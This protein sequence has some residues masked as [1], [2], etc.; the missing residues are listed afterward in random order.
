[1]STILVTGG[2]GYVGS[3]SVLEL[4]ERGHDVIVID[5][6]SAGSH[7]FVDLADEFHQKDIVLASAFDDLRGL[8]IDCI[9]HCAGKAIVPESINDPDLYW[10]TNLLG[11]K[12]IVDNFPSVPIVYSS[13][14]AVYGVPARLPITIATKVV[15][16]S[17]YGNSKLAAEYIIENSRARSA[18]FRYFNVAGADPKLR[19]GE[20]DKSRSRLVPNLLRAAATG[21]QAVIFRANQNTPDMTCI[22]EYVHPSDIATAHA[23]AIEYLAAG[24]TSFK[25]NLGG[26]EASTQEILEK[27]C[28]ATQKIIYSTLLQ[29]RIGD[30]AI[31]CTELAGCENVIGWSRCHG[32]DSIITTAV[33][34]WAKTQGMQ[35]DI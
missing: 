23:D 21:E 16:I 6:L 1:M 25:M 14:C 5:D 10:R 30:P 15:P 19:V 7:E 34:W 32:I 9:L 22:R 26:A 4:K 20:F 2:A 8:R 29:P 27:I 11:T 31:L 33:D 17:P 13:T 24:G 35:L 18:I 3:H 12:N 28:G